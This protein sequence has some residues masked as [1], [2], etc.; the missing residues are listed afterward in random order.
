MIPVVTVAEMNAIDAAAP[1]PVDTLIERAGT[2]VAW[3]ARRMVDGLYG[4]R[5]VVVAGPGNNGA[6]GRVAA[7]L[8]DRWGAAV[9]VVEPTAPDIGPADLV[10]DA[11]FGT[12]LAREYNPP[13]VHGDPLLLAVDV[14]SGV[15]GDTGACL[16]APWSADRTVTFEALKPAHMFGDGPGLCGEIEVAS[17]GL[18]VSGA[19]MHWVEAGEVESM[20]PPRPRDTHKWQAAVLAVAGSADMPGAGRLVCRGALRAGAGYAA[21]V[22][23]DGSVDIGLAD[24]VVQLT[25]FPTPPTLRRFAAAVIGPGLGVDSAQ[26]DQVRSLCAELPM[27]L[28]VDADALRH[29]AEVPG[30]LSVRSDDTVMTPHAGEFAALASGDDAI[31]EARRVAATFAS[32]V[33]L[34]G[35]TTMVVAPDGRVRFV[36]GSDQRL[37]SAGTG[38]VLAGVIGAFLARGVEAF[39]AA[40]AAAVV[41]GSAADLGPAEGLVASDVAEALPDAL[42]MLRAGSFDEA[43]EDDR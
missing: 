25:E 8:L 2:E 24:E 13:S 21:R 14:P 10:I 38:D 35:P 6:D 23:L 7:R 42:A 15:A 12:G 30:A 28:V 4:R 29:I 3:A 16:G 9:E 34:K 26:A 22:G 5:I 18:D 1:E 19:S 17:I 27:P 43:G 39:D 40:T 36:D 31:E 37:A 11:A 20:V 33:L 32:V 41:H